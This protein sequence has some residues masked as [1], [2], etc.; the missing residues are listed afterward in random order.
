[1]KKIISVVLAVVIMMTAL[2]AVGFSASAAETGAQSVGATNGTIGGTVYWSFNSGNGELTISGNGE[3]NDFTSYYQQPWYD[4]SYNVKKITIGSGVTKIGDRAFEYF[5]NLTEVNFSED[6][7]LTKIGEKAFNDCG[8]L[9]SITV[10]KTVKSIGEDAFYDCESLTTFNTTAPVSIGKYAFDYCENLQSVNLPNATSI[11]SYGFTHCKSLKTVSCPKAKFGSYAFGFY[12]IAVETVTAGSL[13]DD[14]LYNIATL[15]TLS[16]TNATTIGDYAV[17]KCPNIKTVSSNA[18]SIGSYAFYE[19]SALTTVKLPKVTS[20]GQYAFAN[21]SSL[22]TVTGTSNLKNIQNGAFGE[23]KKLTKL[24][25]G[26]KLTYIG[27]Q[28]FFDCV[29]L[30][31]SFNAKNITYVGSSAF[32]NCQ[33]LASTFNFKKVK[34]IGSAAFANCKNIKTNTLGTKLTTLGSKS[35]L[36]C[37]KINSIY[38]PPTCKSIGYDSFIYKVTKVTTS[39]SGYIYMDYKSSNV[40]AKIYGNK[41][42][43]AQSYANLHKHKFKVAVKSIKVTKSVKVKKGKTKKLKISIS[44]S[45]AANKSVTL[46]T[47][48]KKIA[49]IN[50]KAVI[51]GVKKGNCVITVTSKDGSQKSAKV[52]VKVY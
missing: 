42:S 25:T 14:A 5:Y 37:S 9:S 36:G 23:D 32:Y 51:K 48:N 50:S 22:T 11:G 16:L 12:D 34:E 49:T 30:T 35:F 38:I 31:G 3:I 8:K 47:S 1:M 18:K 41:G 39:S 46:K 28:A 4:C 43:Q 2:S 20:I 52:K 45:N 29:S 26:S 40:K 33:K 24:V 44:P 6:S 17:Y 27:D 13:D 19:C 7:K 10:P 21:C 15:R